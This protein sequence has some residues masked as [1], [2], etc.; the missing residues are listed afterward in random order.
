MPNPAIPTGALKRT[1]SVEEVATILCGDAGP[2]AQRWVL[3]RLRGYK[4]PT[5]PGYR[6]QKKW[7][8]TQED[9]DSSIELLRPN[10]DQVRIPTLTSLTARSQRRLAV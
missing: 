2:S 3:D 1:Y 8:M 9:V 4:K 7:R 10:P 6:V 5:L